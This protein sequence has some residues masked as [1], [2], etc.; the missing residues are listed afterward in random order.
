MKRKKK[1]KVMW[2]RFVLSLKYNGDMV[3]K[4]ILIQPDICDGCLDCE[5]ACAKL[6]GTSR[7]IV[8]EVD[9]SFYPII[10]QH[11]EDAPCEIICPTEAITDEGIDESKCIGCGLCMMVCPFGS[12]II[13]ERKAHKCTQCPDLDTPACIKACSKRAIA[14]VDT[15]KIQLK[16][17]KQYIENLTELGKK[18][19]KAPFV[20]LITSNT[21]AKK[22]LH[23]EESK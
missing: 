2:I 10:C 3:L 4:K 12:I 19:K 20:N 22:V 18:K 8:R 11:C 1:S 15:E 17:Q 14:L 7:I 9:G 5:E 21:R 23:R 6:Y 16:K 13:H